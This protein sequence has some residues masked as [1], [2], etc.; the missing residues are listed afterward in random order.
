MS[1]DSII[2][3]ASPA[4]ILLAAAELAAGNLIGIPTETVYGLAANA[5]DI[6]AVA[7]IY[8]AKNRPANNP[9]IIHAESAKL[10]R[11]FSLPEL[12]TW[13][14]DQWDIASRFWPGP[15]TVVVP[16]GNQIPDIIT[17]GG[18]HV[19]I[20]VPN[21]AVAIELL[22]RCDF[23]IAAPS[24]NRSNY[25]S[26]TTAQHVADGLG[27]NVSLVLDGGPCESGV[28][29]T[30][31]KLEPK[32]P[33][34]LRP[35]GVSPDELSSAFGQPL[36]ASAPRSTRQDSNVNTRVTG[37]RTLEAP[38][39]LAKHYSPKKRLIIDNG[40]DHVRDA[41][42]SGKRIARIYFARPL[43]SATRDYH[44][45]WV[46][47][48]SGKLLEVASQLYHAIREADQSE[49]DLIV[50]DKCEPTGLGLAI[51]DRVHRAAS[52]AD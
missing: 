2:R 42:Q 13:L 8:K 3:Q 46:L 18:D 19:A 38:G 4:N 17:A 29:S 23:P 44:Q 51:M 6:H 36:I 39:Q 48:D 1:D 5:L 25:V 34:L 12:P 33:R 37:E 52:S 43:D 49:C 15:L 32:G 40:T 11:T 7:K 22:N 24:A 20:R 47:S 27:R 30:I 28:E 14:A 35:G 21:H 31:I 41:V 50:I 16:R 10:A 45:T 26:P 9:L